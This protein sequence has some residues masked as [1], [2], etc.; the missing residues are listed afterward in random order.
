MNKKFSTLVGCLA[1]GT[2]FS[3]NAQ[4]VQDAYR[5]FATTSVSKTSTG[6]AGLSALTGGATFNGA[7]W[8]QDVYHIQDNLLYQL[9]VT[10]GTNIQDDGTDPYVLIQERN[11]ET[12]KIYNLTKNTEYQGQP[13]PAF[14]QKII[15]QGGLVNY[16]NNKK[17]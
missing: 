2:L 4:T 14:M 17:G 8:S 13:F 12:G 1:L 11:Y 7:A 5:T 15:E 16:V 10:A 6:K 3:A 9:Q